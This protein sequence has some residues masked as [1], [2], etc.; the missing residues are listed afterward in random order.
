[1]FIAAKVLGLLLVP[2]GLLILLA[3]FGF[4]VNIKSPRLGKGLF[5][6][7]I[8]MLFFFSVPL[9]GYNL[10]VSLEGQTQALTATHIT[11]MGADAPRVIVVLGAG[12]YADA[13][14]GPVDIR[15][16]DGKLAINM[17]RTPAMTGELTHWQ[18][19]TFL[20]HWR[21]KTIPDAF[22]TFSIG[23]DGHVS[24]ATMEATS[25]LADFSFDYQDL[26][27]KPVSR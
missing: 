10:I 12:R 2:P 27:L 17:T 23:R 20:A 1:M 3:L 7:S 24:Q 15:L 14:Y 11:Q 6:V 16:E 21:D 26:L 13:W 4:L 8:L 9:T 5:A 18:Y 25:E 22:V 19:D